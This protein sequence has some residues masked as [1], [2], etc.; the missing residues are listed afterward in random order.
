M[1]WVNIGTDDSETGAAVNGTN[2]VTVTCTVSPS[3]SGFQVTAS[4]GNATS[5]LVIRGLLS[6]TAGATTEQPNITASFTS[7]LGSYSSGGPTCTVD[8]NANSSETNGTGVMGVAAGRVW[9]NI[10]C[11]S[12]SAANGQQSVCE[13]VAEFKFEDCGS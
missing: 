10:T 3:G 9:G 8:F 11:Q 5:A 4:A 2:G 6:P 12:L 7:T 13:G 1:P